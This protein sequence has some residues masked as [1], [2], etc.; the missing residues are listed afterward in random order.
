MKP[1]D[2]EQVLFIHYRLI[3][4]TGGAHGVR[5]MPLLASAVQRPF[6]TFGKKDLYPDIFLKAA[7]LMHSVIKNHP[8]VDGN[9]RTAV[10]AAS[11]FLKINGYGLKVSSKELERFTMNASTGAVDVEKMAKWF[12]EKAAT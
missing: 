5:D 9:K 12:K 8:F 7:A 1:L 3:E 11:L 4:E 2:C 10:T 6:A